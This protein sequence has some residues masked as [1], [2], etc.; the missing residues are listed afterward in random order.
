MVAHDNAHVTGSGETTLVLHD[1]TEATVSGKSRTLALQHCTVT[2]DSQ[3]EV[4]FQVYDAKEKADI[5]VISPDVS[6]RGLNSPKEVEAYEQSLL[7]RATARRDAS[8]SRSR[9]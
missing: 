4:A 1:H 5:R 3:A 7:E 2:A 6:L 8:A 9:G